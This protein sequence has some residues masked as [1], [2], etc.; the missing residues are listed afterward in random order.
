MRGPG[1]GALGSTGRGDKDVS[2]SGGRQ[3]GE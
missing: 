1:P 3:C 2:N